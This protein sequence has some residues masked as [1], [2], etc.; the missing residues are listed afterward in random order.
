VIFCHQE[1]SLWPVNADA[2][3]LKEKLDEIFDTERIN[4]IITKLD[5]EKKAKRQDL[6]LINKDIEINHRNLKNIETNLQENDKRLKSLESL[7]DKK[8]LNHQSTI[9]SRENIKK[10]ETNVLNLSIYNN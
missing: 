2:R 5:E 4:K 6:E 1:D 9:E 8:N 7:K 3:M 10:I